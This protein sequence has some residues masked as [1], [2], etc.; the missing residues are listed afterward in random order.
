MKLFGIEYVNQCGADK[1][2][3]KPNS[4]IDRAII[5]MRLLTLFF[6]WNPNEGEAVLEGIMY[7]Y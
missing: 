7:L 6:C 3:K 5:G 4:L 2:K 1:L